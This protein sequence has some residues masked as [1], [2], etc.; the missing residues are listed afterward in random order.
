MAKWKDEVLKNQFGIPIAAVH[1]VPWCIFFDSQLY[2]TTY[3]MINR[4][5]PNRYRKKTFQKY[6]RKSYYRLMRKSK[7]KHSKYSE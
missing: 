1:Y 5:Y 3:E 4:S 2:K 7:L 6:N